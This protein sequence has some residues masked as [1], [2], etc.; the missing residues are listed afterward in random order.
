MDQCRLAQRAGQHSINWKLTA[1]K[2]KFKSILLSTPNSKKPKSS[3][4][5]LIEIPEDTVF[6]HQIQLSRLGTCPAGL[7]EAKIFAEGEE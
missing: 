4:A 5:A 7:K 3:F 2:W 6:F 1:I